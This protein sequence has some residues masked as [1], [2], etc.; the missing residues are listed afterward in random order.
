MN[1]NV[2]RA[3]LN[4]SIESYGFSTSVKEVTVASCETGTC[5]QY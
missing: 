5:K 2:L 3:D 4:E 1:K